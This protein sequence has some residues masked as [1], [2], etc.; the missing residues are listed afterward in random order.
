MAKNS[1]IGF[2]K[3]VAYL[4]KRRTLCQPS[5]NMSQRG[6]SQLGCPGFLITIVIPAQART[7]PA[8]GMVSAKDKWVP[9]YT[10]TTQ[11]WK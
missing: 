9:A 2:D 10:G 3:I 11:R 5:F 6:M 7:H 8:I 4:R 1:K